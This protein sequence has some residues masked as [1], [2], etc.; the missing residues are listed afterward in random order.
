MKRD[1]LDHA[2]LKWTNGDLGQQF[3][4]V[5]DHLR[6]DCDTMLL[7][8]EDLH[9]ISY[10]I[11]DFLKFGMG[12]QAGPYETSIRKWLMDDH[13]VVREF[14]SGATC[15][16]NEV[17]YGEKSLHSLANDLMQVALIPESELGFWD[18]LPKRVGTIDPTFDPTFARI[19]LMKYYPM[20]PI[21]PKSPARRWMVD[22]DDLI[23]H[24]RYDSEDGE[25]DLA[26]IEPELETPTASRP[27]ASSKPN[28]RD[29][30]DLLPNEEKF[31][32]LLHGR[33]MTA[34][35]LAA[36]N[37]LNTSEPTIHQWKR[38]INRKRPGLIEHS[39]DY[40]YYRTD[41][42]PDWSSLTRKRRRQTRPR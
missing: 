8:L 7:E 35:E 14:K 23:T 13:R 12:R 9:A 37:R 1:E 22:L 34:A 41:A 42:E 19:S 24:S 39:K 18:V 31:I 32:D 27:N 36:P 20:R 38:N 10:G 5:T 30:S 26:G 15:N 40:G 4:P 16:F 3:A 17:Y 21:P 2:G 29:P 6:A 28:A 25:A 33:A 11:A